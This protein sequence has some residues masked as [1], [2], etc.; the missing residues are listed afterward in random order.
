MRQWVRRPTWPSARALLAV[1]GPAEPE[2]L[3][4]PSQ[5]PQPLSKSVSCSSSLERT[6][7][8]IP[9]IVTPSLSPP[10]PRKPS[11]AGLGKHFSL[12]LELPACLTG[13]DLVWLFQ[14][15]LT[16]STAPESL[17]PPTPFPGL[18]GLVQKDRENL[19][20]G[21]ASWALI[22]VPDTG[23]GIQVR[24]FFAPDSP[25]AVVQIRLKQTTGGKPGEGW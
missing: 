11:R 15:H 8:M 24:A 19:G 1:L 13:L 21:S 18:F 6:L 12:F 20:K 25:P 10:L 22:Q 2:L 5:L 7:L 16:P 14:H 3:G 9:E 17:F 4:P 23:P